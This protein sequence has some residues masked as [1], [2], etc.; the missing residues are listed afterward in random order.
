[1]DI[2]K[3]ESTSISENLQ[4]NRNKGMSDKSCVV[5]KFRDLFSTMKIKVVRRNRRVRNR[6]CRFWK[7][8]RMCRNVLDTGTGTEVGV[9]GDGCV[10]RDHG[11]L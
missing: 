10:C 11:R 7:C 4:E 8:Y 6:Y 1:M 5:R 9:E 3:G 2:V